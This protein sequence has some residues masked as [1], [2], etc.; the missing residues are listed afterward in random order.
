MTGKKRN[1]DGLAMQGLYPEGSI[2]CLW[3]ATSRNLALD[4][5]DPLNTPQAALGIQ[6]HGWKLAGE[7]LV[8]EKT[9]IDVRVPTSTSR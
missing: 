2:R 5:H 1:A 9:S 4:R 7:L 6:L 3:F 8:G